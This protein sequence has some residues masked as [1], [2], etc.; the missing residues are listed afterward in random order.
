MYSK[1]LV[2]LYFLIFK[3]NDK[4]SNTSSTIFSLCTCKEEETSWPCWGALK[5]HSWEHSQRSFIHKEMTWFYSPVL[6]KNLL[7][8]VFTPWWTKWRLGCAE[9]GQGIVVMMT[10][11]FWFMSDN[12]RRPIPQHQTVPAT[13][14]YSWLCFVSFCLNKSQDADL[15]ASSQYCNRGVMQHASLLLSRQHC[16]S[17]P[18]TNKM[19]MVEANGFQNCPCNNMPSAKIYFQIHLIWH[20]VA[21]N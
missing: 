9:G 18:Y 16:S 14:T 20:E 13:K 8:L 5:R 21:K 2:H 17:W 7:W 11:H 6:W 3:T 4:F 10:W 12:P 1:G 19:L 15:E